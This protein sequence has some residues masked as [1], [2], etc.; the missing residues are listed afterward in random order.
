[1]TRHSDLRLRICSPNQLPLFDHGYSSLSY[2]AEETFRAEFNVSKT[3][4]LV[5]GYPM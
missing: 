4:D 1:M 3:L 2:L 5:D